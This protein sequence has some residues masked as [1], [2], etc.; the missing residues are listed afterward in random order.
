MSAGR[1]NPKRDQFRNHSHLPWQNTEPLRSQLL[2]V[3]AQYGYEHIDMPIVEASDIYLLKAGE[4]FATQL[5]ELVSRRRLSLRPEHT[6]SVVRYIAEQVNDADAPMRISYVGPVFRR[7][8]E[9]AEPQ[10]LIEIGIELFGLAGLAGELE[11]LTLANRF[12]GE[13]KLQEYQPRIGQVGIIQRF[14]DSQ[15]LDRRLSSFLLMHRQVIRDEGRAAILELLREQLPEFY[16]TATDAN[17]QEERKQL[18]ELLEPLKDEEARA[19]L[20]DFLSL[21]QLVEDVDG[22]DEDDVDRL[23]TKLRRADSSAQ[24]RTAIGFIEELAQLVGEPKD[25]ITEARSLLEHYEQDSSDLD[26]LETILTYLSTAGNEPKNGWQL[27]LGLSRGLHYYSGLIFEIFHGEGNGWQRLGGGGRYDGLTELFGGSATPAC[28]FSF[29]LEWLAQAQFREGVFETSGVEPHPLVVSETDW[30][31][32]LPWV[33]KMRAVG[34]TIVMMPQ[35]RDADTDCILMQLDSRGP[36]FSW[37]AAGQPIETLD[38][39]E[40]LIRL[41]GKRELVDD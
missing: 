11:L 38:W 30:A 20:S 25:V 36:R 19:V 6:A 15:G 2:A 5:C 17:G 10:Q 31:E 29:S 32:A 35:K 28:G 16:D 26:V 22:P 39:D 14:L 41:Q 1:S 9:F 21:T 8:E 12:M 3:A 37:I 4:T 24:V 23:L 33:E 7:S 18:R 40:T 13:L 27:D 34:C